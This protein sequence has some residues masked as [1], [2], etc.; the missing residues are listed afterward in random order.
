[1]EKLLTQE[2][3]LVEKKQE[4]IVMKEVSEVPIMNNEDKPLTFLKNLNETFKKYSEAEDAT[5]LE[6]F[7]AAVLLVMKRKGNHTSETLEEIYLKSHEQQKFLINNLNEE[8]KKLKHS[9]KQTKSQLDTLTEKV[10]NLECEKFV[11]ADSIMKL[12]KSSSSQSSKA[13]TS[14]RRSLCRII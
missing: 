11:A 13:K 1:L 7:E 10:T 8:L 12:S 2:N 3:D 6:S 4:I 9:N 14:T 5:Y